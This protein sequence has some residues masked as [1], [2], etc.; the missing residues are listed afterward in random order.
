MCNNSNNLPQKLNCKSNPPRSRLQQRRKSNPA[1]NSNP[2]RDP[3]PPCLNHVKEKTP[4]SSTAT[5][6][7]SQAP[8]SRWPTSE[9]QNPPTLKPYNI[10]PK[11]LSPQQLNRFNTRRHR[12]Y[13]DSSITSRSANWKPRNAWTQNWNSKTSNTSRNVHSPQN[14]SQQLRSPLSP[15]G[16]GP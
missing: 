1:L 7:L 15:Q 6:S 11:P 16:G 4:L 13:Q 5:Y 12:S 10:N 9:T 14:L 8:S 2:C 3:D